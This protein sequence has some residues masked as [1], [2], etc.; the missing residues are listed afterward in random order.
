MSTEPD[1]NMP[2]LHSGSCT[3]IPYLNI[4][5]NQRKLH[6]KSVVR[7]MCADN[8]S[9]YSS[10]INKFSSAVLLN[11]LLNLKSRNRASYVNQ[12]NHK[13]ECT[14]QEKFYNFGN[15]MRDLLLTPKIFR[16]KLLPKYWSY[17]VYRM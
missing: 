1:G 7:D 15:K 3:R 16:K 11:A 13:C 10:I 6:L 17:D 8:R 14:Q 2:F 12:V 4:L 9:I 5:E